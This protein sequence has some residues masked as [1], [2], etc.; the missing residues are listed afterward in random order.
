MTMSS[1]IE[2]VSRTDPG[3]VRS[4]NED[5]VAHELNMGVVL[6]ADGMGGY[7]AGEVASGMAARIIVEGLTHAWRG[8]TENK[9][10]LAN[11]IEIAGNSIQQQVE[12]ANWAIFEKAQNE[13]QCAGMGTTLV[14][15]LFYDNQLTV[16]HIGDSRMYRLR[17][18]VLEQITKDHSL[19]QEQVDGGLISKEDARKSRNKN[20]LTRA[21]GIDPKVE[22]E[23]HSHDV[24]PGD[25]YLVCSDGLNDM[26]EDEEIRLTLLA[27]QSNLALA[28]E[29]LVMSA[30]DNG[31]R[32]NISVVLVRILQPFPAVR[33][34]MARLKS[35]FSSRGR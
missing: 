11:G 25:T 6:L 14:A 30:N 10:A 18:E 15:G 21:L 29:Q 23:I 32:D 13:P 34:W 35:W 17:G 24:L 31:G 16:G 7:N 20:L 19:L 8:L 9:P 22:A 12:R 1:A 28:A 5:F 2:I 27:L 33:G 4:H 3:K 26:V